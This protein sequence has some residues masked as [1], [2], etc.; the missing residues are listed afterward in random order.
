[1]TYASETAC[2]PT[3]WQQIQDRVDSLDGT[4]SRS[5]HAAGVWLITPTDVIIDVEPKT[6][7]EYLEPI[8]GS[9]SET[10]S[11]M[12]SISVGD[13]LAL[14]ADQTQDYL[15]KVDAYEQDEERNLRARCA[16]LRLHAYYA[17]HHRHSTA[18]LADQDADDEPREDIR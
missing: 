11:N 7:A 14:N 13:I 18:L 15:R 17:Q 1:M 8:S 9:L 4:A 12:G 3:S 6:L 2:I 10:V 16:A 5:E